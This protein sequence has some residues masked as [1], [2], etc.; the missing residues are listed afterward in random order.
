MGKR[1][2]QEAK[3]SRWKTLQEA[4]IKYNKVL[5]VEVDNVTSKQICIMRRQ[6]RAI[7]AKMVMGKNTMMKRAI[8][9]LQTEPNE[10]TMDPEEYAQKKA[11]Y[12][13]RPYLNLIKEQLKLNIGMIF[14][15]GD[16]SEIKDILDT[17]V[18]EAPAKVG[19]IA[20]KEVVVP[21]GP[22]GMDPKQT[23]FFQALNI[24]TKIVKAQIEIAAPVTVIKEGDKISASQATLLDRLK[25]RPFEYKMH[26]K[27]FLDNGK[28]FP[29]RVL[30]ISSDDVVAS[31]VD[32]AN[33]LTAISLAS[34]Y[35]VPSATPHLIVNA[36]K[37]LCGAALAANYDF[38]QLAA[39]KA[40]ASSGPA[41]AKAAGGGAA[42]EEKAEEKKP[43]EDEDD[44][45]EGMDGLF[46]GDDDY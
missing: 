45:I 43:E 28:I 2:K 12:K 15:N 30:S 41:P 26:I 10:A 36:F 4:F 33:N 20:P 11:I 46:G 3:D 18:R 35:H 37:N 32:G 25:I 23:Q 9:D 38:P 1:S 22:T 6:L 7:D 39:I 44:G 24:A 13:P 34:G 16:L 21:P 31:F 8:V 14:T 19:A 29:A 27:C 42:K 40:S 5:F 17:Q